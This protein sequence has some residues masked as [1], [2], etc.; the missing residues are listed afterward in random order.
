MTASLEL[1][2]PHFPTLRP[3]ET[4]PTA[5]PIRVVGRSH[6]EAHMLF[7]QY[8][9]QATFAINGRQATTQAKQALWL[10][11]GVV[12][13]IHV[14]ADSVLLRIFFRT[15]RVAL[16]PEL[17][18]PR[19]FQ[20][21]EELASHLMGMVQSD[22]SLLHTSI[23]LDQHIVDHLGQQLR[24]LPWPETPAAR[25]VALLLADSPGISHTL[26]TLAEMVHA[27]PRTIERAFITE[28]GETFQQW[29]MQA[30]MAKAKQLIMDGLS[31]DSVALRVGYSTASA[32]GRA[33]KKHTDLSP[34]A[35][36][37]KV[38]GSSSHV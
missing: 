22:S 3:T 21:D 11:A 31:I 29:R 6:P 28:T 16:T 38:T 32:F 18:V 37:A 9:G 17:H 7:W 20:V 25:E 30:R 23:G 33:F 10:P 27:S 35:Y 19:L 12:H 13:D 4:S 36:Y 2:R 34:S 8:R 14:G 26:H 1:S 15:H 5:P 24:A